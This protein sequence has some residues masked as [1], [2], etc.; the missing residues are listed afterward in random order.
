MIFGHAAQKQGVAPFIT[1]GLQ[2]LNGGAQGTGTDG[3]DKGAFAFVAEFGD[4]PVFKAA[5]QLLI[6]L[7]PDIDV[8]EII[9]GTGTVLRHDD[10]INPGLVAEGNGFEL[11]R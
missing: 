5:D 11:K 3:I 1:E 4:H 10:G 7:I 2:R 8:A 9:V 6:I